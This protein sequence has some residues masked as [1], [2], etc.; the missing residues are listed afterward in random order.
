LLSIVKERCRT[1]SSAAKGHRRT[2][3]LKLKALSS[4]R[5]IIRYRV[6]MSTFLFKILIIISYKKPLIKSVASRFV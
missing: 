1:L 3:F 6:S 2:S 4:G 5:R